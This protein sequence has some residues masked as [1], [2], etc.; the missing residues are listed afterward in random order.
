MWIRRS[1]TTANTFKH[2]QHKRYLWN[3]AQSSLRVHEVSPARCKECPDKCWAKFS[4]LDSPKISARCGKKSRKTA[5]LMDKKG[6]YY[7]SSDSFHIQIFF[8]RPLNF[9]LTS[10]PR[11][12]VMFLPPSARGRWAFSLIQWLPGDKSLEQDW[13]HAQFFS[14]FALFLQLYKFCRKR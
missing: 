3:P 7:F 10:T 1:V 11:L 13:Y 2:I 14:L 6:L 12:R 9:L 5:R 4:K 8:R